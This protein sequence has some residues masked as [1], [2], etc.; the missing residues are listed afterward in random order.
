MNMLTLDSLLPDIYLDS[1]R[2]GKP[3]GKS[4]IH[5][6]HKCSRD[7]TAI[8]RQR[9]RETPEGQLQ[10]D[11][12][13]RYRGKTAPDRS[14]SAVDKS[15]LESLDSG[16]TSIRDI[17][18]KS[19]F[20]P[21][22]YGDDPKYN[23]VSRRLAAL[24]AGGVIKLNRSPD[25]VT[26]VEKVGSASEKVES[27]PKPFPKFETTDPIDLDGIM[28]QIE[29]IPDGTISA[30]EIQKRWEQ[31]KHN[32]PQIDADLNKL[33]KAKL[34]KWF[35]VGTY[36]DEKKPK[37]VAD[38]KE[39]IFDYFAPPSAP[40][41]KNTFSFT[42]I[43][44]RSKMTQADKDKEHRDRVDKSIGQWTDKDVD[45]IAADARAR[46]E[47]RR[48]RNEE[49]KQS[50]ENPKTLE[51]FRRFLLVKDKSDMTTSQQRLYEQLNAEKTQERI[52]QTQANSNRVTS[53]QVKGRG[54]DDLFQPVQKTVHAKKNHDLYVVAMAGD[55]IPRE[56]FQKLKDRAKKFDGYY[57]S[58]RGRGAIPGFQFRDEENA[59]KF[60][61]LKS[62][63][64]RDT[65]EKNAQ[66]RQEKA[67]TNLKEVS[68]RLA[69]RA[70][71]TLEQQKH[72]KV[73]T[74]RRIGMSESVKSRAYE[75]QAIATTMTNIA[76]HI[77]AGN[78]KILSRVR[79]KSDV[80]S[81][82]RLFSNSRHHRA[83]ADRRAILAPV[84]ADAMKEPI[85][86]RERRAFLSNPVVQKRLLQA[87]PSGKMPKSVLDEEIKNDRIS[88]ALNRSGAR[89]KASDAYTEAS[90][91][92]ADFDSI[93]FAQYPYPAASASQLKDIV[94]DN[95]NRKGQKMRAKRLQKVIA[96]KNLSDQVVFRNSKFIGDLKALTDS[97]IKNGKNPWQ[98]SWIRD[99]IR[100]YDRLQRLG[101][102]G[103]NELRA[104]L[105][106]F[107]PL[108][109]EPSKTDKLTR[110]EQGL[111][112]RKVGVDF[113]PTPEALSDRVV[114]EADI[115]PHHKVLEPSAGSGR[116]ADAAKRAG[117]TNITTVELSSDLREVLTLKGYTPKSGDFLTFNEGK[118]TY[119]RI[120]MNPPFSNGADI[121]HV[122]HAYKLLKPGGKMVA[123]MSEGPFFRNRKKDVEFRDWLGSVG[124]SERLP[125][126]SF[127]ESNTGVNTRLVTI[128]KPKTQ[129][130]S[131]SQARNS[132]TPFLLRRSASR[133]V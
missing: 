117:A 108:R 71:E 129:I 23:P 86:E 103:E 125:E 25:G 62:D 49:Y 91:K 120:T 21:D 9:L 69:T 39:R 19:G 32:E 90:K 67:T 131:K 97:S 113:F 95:I 83:E 65:A 57:S 89:R 80:E 58:Y 11:R 37:L 114:R 73:N 56:E 40:E 26:T 82:E 98:S 6:R 110:A 130:D 84:E 123:I 109:K 132:I 122:R 106:E 92:G 20:P 33:T 14:R 3:C 63:D 42:E 61:A 133:R 107:Y 68:E 54:A 81:L 66:A 44:R 104:A 22:K 87:F 64:G 4:Y 126:G 15:I 127:K 10:K 16:T 46:R 100:D 52:A 29:R 17:Q 75:D 76:D 101:I 38:A 41:P 1:K 13:A 93:D 121:D 116:L 88:K 112:G 45:E 47:A 8:A 124:D 35:G 34:R 27:K 7:K 74:A 85:S 111:T 12:I 30:K 60:R 48:A 70:E 43:M 102:T 118:G 5:W 77:D 119:D 72:A 28:D 99:E 94:D 50:L 53:T 18:S 105:R 36:R 2:P 31:F 128:Y 96:D 79:T 59:A 78:A 51:D 55:R 24:E 115:K